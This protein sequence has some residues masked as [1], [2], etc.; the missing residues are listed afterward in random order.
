[1]FIKRCFGYAVDQINR[2]SGRVNSPALKKTLNVLAVLTN[3]P[4][5][6]YDWENGLVIATFFNDIKT[7][8]DTGG[9]ADETRTQIQVQTWRQV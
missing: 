1:M 4:N 6:W 5:R 2:L 8:K 7:V 3:E 9:L